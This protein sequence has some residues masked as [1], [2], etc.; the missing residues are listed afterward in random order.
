M[1]KISEMTHEELQDYAIALEEEK[2]QNSAK[3]QQL[4]GEN[5]SLAELNHTLQK[6]NN[7]LFMKVEAQ[8]IQDDPAKQNEPEQVETCEDF[9]KRLIEKGV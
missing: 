4:E 1:K 3:L 8:F 5:K 2:A 6:R 7:D 9:A